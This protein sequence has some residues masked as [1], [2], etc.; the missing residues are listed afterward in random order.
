MAPVL[1]QCLYNVHMLPFPGGV[2]V[3]RTEWTG[4]KP[5][6]LQALGQSIVP[7]SPDWSVEGECPHKHKWPFNHRGWGFFVMSSQQVLQNSFNAPAECLGPRLEPWMGSFWHF[8]FHSSHGMAKEEEKLPQNNSNG[9]K[10]FIGMNF[11]LIY[12]Q[13]LVIL[14]DW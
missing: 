6:R 1:V 11:H 2:A 5:M 9:C 3:C 12:G 14:A 4:W 7:P 8:S 13:I 10:I